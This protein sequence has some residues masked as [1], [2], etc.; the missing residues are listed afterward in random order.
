MRQIDADDLLVRLRGNVLVDVTPALEEAINE[1][2]TVFGNGS[3]ADQT[4]EIADMLETKAN[5]ELQKAT[6]YHNGYI[7]ACVDFGRALRSNIEN[8]ENV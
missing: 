4:H 2:P 7:Q 6:S 5:I 1:Q 8:K 3:T